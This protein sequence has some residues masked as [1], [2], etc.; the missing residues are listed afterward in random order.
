MKNTITDAIEYRNEIS[1]ICNKRFNIYL[2]A[3]STDIILCYNGQEHTHDQINTK[4]KK[5]SQKMKEFL[6][7]LYANKTT[8]YDKVINHIELARKTRNMFLD[9]KNPEYR[10]HEYR[11]KKFRESVLKPVVSVGDITE[12]CETNRLFPPNPDDPFI[13]NFETCDIHQKMFFRFCMTTP[14]LLLMMSTVQSFCID[15]TY[16]L[17]WLG[18]PLIVFGT[19][20]RMK[21]F[22]PL[23][24]GCTSSKTSDDYR[25]IFQ[26]IKEGVE[27][28]IVKRIDARFLIADGAHAIKNGFMNIFP[29]A[30]KVI[31]YFAHVIRNIQ[32][33]SFTSKQ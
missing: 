20:D 25:F 9:E 33:R 30:E 5:L 2:P 10:Q 3:H 13:L 8:S 28:D 15:A 31:M 14:H 29:E 4:T 18:F 24:Y 7:D 16:K 27:K 17:N 12:F 22:H 32:K 11:L 19:V 23:L 1:T 21:R 26:S 6:N